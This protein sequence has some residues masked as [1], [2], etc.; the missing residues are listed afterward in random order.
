[1]SRTDDKREYGKGNA[2]AP[3]PPLSRMRETVDAGALSFLLVALQGYRPQPL[4]FGRLCHP[5]PTGRGGRRRDAR[6]MSP[7]AD[8]ISSASK[9]DSADSHA[10]THALSAAASLRWFPR[11]AASAARPGMPR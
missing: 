4:A 3:A 1:A 10:I 6:A 7:V 9:L 8:G 2:A 5:R 11:K